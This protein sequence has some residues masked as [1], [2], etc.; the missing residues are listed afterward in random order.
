MSSSCSSLDWVLSHWVHF[1]VRR[2]ICVYLS[3]FLFHTAYLLYYR[4][5]GGVGLMGLKP[6]PKDQA[7]FSAV[8]LLVGSFDPQK[9]VPDMTYNVFG[10]TLNLDQL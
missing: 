6:N 9:P 4:E 1:T 5:H 8:T 3:V 7:S 2:F 10:G